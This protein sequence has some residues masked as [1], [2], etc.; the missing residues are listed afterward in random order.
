LRAGMHVIFTGPPGTGKTKLAACICEKAGFPYW[1][2]P[3]T[4]QWTTFDTIGGYFPAPQEDGTADRLDFL[5]GPVVDS[6]EKGQCLII[7]EI[8]RADI[9]KAF[10]ELF[11]L[12][13]GNTVTLPYGDVRRRGSSG[14]AFKWAQ[15]LSNLT[16]IRY[17]F[18]T[19]GES[20][21]P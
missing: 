11:T 10:G 12:L 20:S 14:C 3:A 9:D 7:D 6:V 8:N 16:S 1:T 13:T 4:D 21:E 2:V 15:L 17:R 18:R 5:P 19:G